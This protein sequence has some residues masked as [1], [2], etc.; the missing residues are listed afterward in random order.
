MGDYNNRNN[1]EQSRNN[2]NSRPLTESTNSGH[3]GKFEHSGVSNDGNGRI[4]TTS[5]E[6]N[7]NPPKQGK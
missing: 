7:G 1:G 4:V 5:Q 6:T 3:G 2:G